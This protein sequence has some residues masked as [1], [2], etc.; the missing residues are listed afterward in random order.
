[1]KVR[2]CSAGQQSQMLLRQFKIKEI[3]AIRFARESGTK[4]AVSYA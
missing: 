1:M 3:A 2:H 4:V